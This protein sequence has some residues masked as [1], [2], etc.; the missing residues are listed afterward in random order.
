LLQNKGRIYQK[1][2]IIANRNIKGQSYQILHTF[3]YA[4]RKQRD[5][6]I[7][8]KWDLNQLEKVEFYET[9]YVKV[10]I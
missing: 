10:R 8:C 5:N 3:L 2:K 1:N 4:W 9:I 6:N 7:C